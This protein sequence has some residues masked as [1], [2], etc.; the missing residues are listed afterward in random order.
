MNPVSDELVFALCMGG[1]GGCCI[2]A[3]PPEAR[4]MPSGALSE[5]LKTFYEGSGPEFNEFLPHV[6]VVI[7]RS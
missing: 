3:G 2:Q 5:V 7:Y 1:P 4:V 6:S